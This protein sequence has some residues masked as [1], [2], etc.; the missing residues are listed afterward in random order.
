MTDLTD[1]LAAL[2]RE[3]EE[4]LT[5]CTKVPGGAF[6]V[7]P[8]TVAGAPEAVAAHSGGADTWY[9]VQPLRPGITAAKRGEAADVVGLRCLYADLDVKAGGMPTA[10]AAEE[11]IGDLS[12]M[13]GA[14][15][16]AVVDSGHGLQPYWRLEPWDWAADDHGSRAAAAH[17]LAG[18]KRLVEL[19]AD[20]RGG[21][22]DPVFDLPRILR[23]P[24]TENQGKK[25]AP[26][27]VPTKLDL[28]G[29][30]EVSVLAVREAIDTYVP[31]ATA[32]P[33]ASGGSAAGAREHN[34]LGGEERTF[35]DEQARAFIEPALERLRT[36]TAGADGGFHG[37]LL[38]ACPILGHFVGSHWTRDEVLEM[39]EEA[40]RAAGSV[41]IDAGGHRKTAED[42]LDLALKEWQAVRVEEL[43]DDLDPEDDPAGFTPPP[44]SKKLSP[45]FHD[46]GGFQ[47]EIAVRDLLRMAPMRATAE[48]GIAVYSGGVYRLDERWFER[49]V[50]IML[51]NLASLSLIKE[52]RAAAASR[53]FARGLV[54]ADHATEPLLNLRNGMLDL[55]TL[56]L[57][58]HDPKY[59]ST[60]QLGIDWNPEATCPHYERWLV[61]SVK[62]EQFQALEELT[63]TMLDPSRTPTKALLL[64]GPSRS[65]KSTYL[66]IM[67]A[68]AGAENTSGVDLHQLADDKFMAAV[69]YGKTLNI[70]ADLSAKDVGD[71]SLFKKLTGD[72]VIQANRK[73]GRTFDFVNRA[74]FAFSANTLPAVNE[75]SR[76]YV[77][78]VRAIEFPNSFAGAEDP[79]IE[80]RIMGELQ[81][82]L[83]RWATA[84]QRGYLRGS[85][86]PADA[87]VQARFEAGSDRVRQFISGCCEVDPEMVGFTT[88]TD[89]YAA[90]RRWV[91]EQG[92]SRLGR[93]M[94]GARLAH[95]PGV[96]AVVQSGKVRGYKVKV[97]P[98][99]EW[100]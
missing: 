44:A 80:D 61:N 22:V 16:A 93:N 86:L 32:A 96:K 71:V 49:A 31:V 35:T 76:A 50:R 38:Y 30:G 88:T 70:A 97:L 4:I 18:W 28:R 25:Y 79:R 64:F 99:T 55:R 56:E 12:D 3:P 47:V 27:I 90:F 6:K 36:T 92:G 63:A 10:E 94:F 68:I 48:G 53:Q 54:T 2:G 37:A 95:S 67:R 85:A 15:P 40:M 65:G 51:G 52:A 62:L 11:V 66:R 78:R 34:L 1:L 89:L 19:V 20:K 46:G 81:G 14:A 45:Y 13:L 72:D 9:S 17:L 42:G 58:P 84:W 87:D 43:P 82:I 41:G 75:S 39:I 8:T 59:G 69:L 74:L 57:L 23:V 98:S 21:E 33:A 29:G 26:G 77:E 73:Y 100:S 7:H 5:V 91:E 83:V 24:G 60:V